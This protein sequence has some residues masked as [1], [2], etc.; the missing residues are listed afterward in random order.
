MVITSPG[1]TGAVLTASPSGTTVTTI[2]GVPTT[3]PGAVITIDGGP[4]ATANIVGPHNDPADF[5][6]IILG[7]VA[8]IVAIILTRMIFRRT[9]GSG[10]EVEGPR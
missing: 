5:Y 1:W 8:I 2:P 9:G 4:N 7:L 3:G 6:G 10:A